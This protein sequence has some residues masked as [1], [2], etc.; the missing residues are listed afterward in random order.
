MPS[1]ILPSPELVAIAL[2]KNHLEILDHT[3]I[4]LLEI[5]ISL[6]IGIIIGSVF[7]I[8]ISSIG[9][10]RW[11]A[12]DPDFTWLDMEEILFNNGLY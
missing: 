2:Y 1:F 4:T 7:A 11:G 8:L 6:I 12:T 5:I 10:S 9:S 3:F